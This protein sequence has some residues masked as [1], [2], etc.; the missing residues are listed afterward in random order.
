MS[1]QVWE[2]RMRQHCQASTFEL[3]SP[4]GCTYSKQATNVPACPADHQ[5]AQAAVPSVECVN[6]QLQKAN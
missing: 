3:K 6:K 1:C 4:F 2:H 5:E